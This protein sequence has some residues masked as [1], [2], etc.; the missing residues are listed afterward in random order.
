[1]FALSVE[2]RQMTVIEEPEEGTRVVFRRSPDSE[3]TVLIR[4]VGEGKGHNTFV[5]GSC[6][7]LLLVEVQPH[8]ILGGVFV[9]N[10]CGSYNEPLD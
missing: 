3:G 10:S 9:C 4:G 2:V 6:R 5:C 8:T 7:S 1:M